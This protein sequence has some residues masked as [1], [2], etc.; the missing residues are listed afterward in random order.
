M[1]ILLYG[2]NG[3]LGSDCNEVLSEEFEV[4]AP[5]R[6]ELDITKWDPVIDNIHSISPDIVLNC[7]GYADVDGCEKNSFL[8]IL[9]PI[10]IAEL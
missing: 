3:M 9:S 10:R 4:I 7:A 1:K 6:K 8:V 5:T 2:V